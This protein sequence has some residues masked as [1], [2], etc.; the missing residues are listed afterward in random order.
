MEQKKF[1]VAY[2]PK[3]KLISIEISGV[4]YERLSNFVLRHLT[5]FSEQEADR[6]MTMIKDR[7]A[8]LDVKAYDLETLF[9]LLHGIE[10]KFNQKGYITQEEVIV[11]PEDQL[12]DQEDDEEDSKTED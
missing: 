1:N 9:T 6:A 11:T 3:D 2:V 5:T 10:E 7:T 12:D 4:F 8:H